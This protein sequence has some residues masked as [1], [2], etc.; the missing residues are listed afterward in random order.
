MP[1]RCLLWNCSDDSF[2][3]IRC[4]PSRRAPR[5]HRDAQAS[6]LA[7][8][9]LNQISRPDQIRPLRGS[10]ELIGVVVMTGVI[11]PAPDLHRAAGVSGG[12]P[13]DEQ[14]GFARRNP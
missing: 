4:K 3:V 13:F 1:R 12:D 5:H 7:G 14:Q 6:L 8:A 10:L 9:I 2:R 11:P